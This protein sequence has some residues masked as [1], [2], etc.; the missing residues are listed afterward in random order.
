MSFPKKLTQKL[1][2]RIE[3]NSLRT[4][5]QKN[6]LIDFSSNDYLGFAK[7]EAIFNKTHQFLIDNSILQNGATGSRLLSGNHH[8]YNSIEKE[9]SKFHNSE[10]ALIFNSGYDAN[11]GFFSAVPQRG[12]IILYDEFIHASIRD[13]IQLSNA[14][15][16]KFKHN[17]LEDLEKKISKHQSKN[18]TEI[19][20]VTEAVFS[21]DGDMPDLK[22]LS[23]IIIQNNAYL[24]ID[25][26]HA[27]GVFNKGLVQELNIENAIFARIITFG[28][29]MG[30]H[31]AVILT[32]KEL[33][34]YLINFSRSFIYTTGL[35]PHSL[36][37][38]K[39]AYSELIE[40]DAKEKLQKNILFFKKEIN[41]LQ[42]DFITSNSA[43]H[44]CIISGN[45]NVK[46]IAKQLKEKG[47]DVKAILSPTVNKGEERLRFC[48]HSY[49]SF[50]EITAVLEH[51]TTFV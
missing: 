8:L 16:F 41:R 13:G 22:K 39:F 7:S 5:G 38:I 51:L 18:D 3:N 12:D 23:E 20:V 10:E 30:C 40:S 32:S 37:T 21:M 34:L 44:C 28:K 45:E 14:Q 25:E 4:L 17:N 15:S 42:L 6:T 43:I 19:Y 33:K 29:A 47:F 31:G 26:A 48:L 1:L 2:H 27:V 46:K 11:I 9:L 35:S 36:A 24:I 49:N 50:E